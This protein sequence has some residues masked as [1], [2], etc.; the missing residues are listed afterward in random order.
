MAKLENGK[1]S[2]E[3]KVNYKAGFGTTGRQYWWVEFKIDGY[4]Y[5]TDPP[6]TNNGGWKVQDLTS[7]DSNRKVTL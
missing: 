3:F 2:Q 6:M 4:Y 1:E 5:E 7:A